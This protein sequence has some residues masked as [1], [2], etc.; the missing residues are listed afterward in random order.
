MNDACESIT[1]HEHN[2]ILSNLVCLNYRSLGVM[3][4]CN[5][6]PARK[7]FQATSQF[8]NLSSSD[9]VQPTLGLDLDE[10]IFQRPNVAASMGIYIHPSILA[11]AR[12]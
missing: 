11:E 1:I 3:T 6:D 12:D 2:R 10:K 5:N 8:R 9:R 7:R 4:S